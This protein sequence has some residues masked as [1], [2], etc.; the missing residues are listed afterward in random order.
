[1]KA[2]KFVT[3]KFVNLCTSTA[4]FV[5]YDLHIL[6]SGIVHPTAINLVGSGTVVSVP[7]F[8]K[9]LNT[10]REKGVK[11]DNRIFVSDRAH[12]LFELRMLPQM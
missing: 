5:Q 11:S 4:K 10:L 8:F 2:S 7:Q 9:E 3:T 12:L 1:M 6:P